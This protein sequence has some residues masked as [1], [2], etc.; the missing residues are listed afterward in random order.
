MLQCSKSHWA[1]KLQRSFEWKATACIDIV[2]NKFAKKSLFSLHLKIYRTRGY[3]K[4]H[5]INAIYSLSLDNSIVTWYFGNASFNIS[6]VTLNDFLCLPTHGKNMCYLKGKAL[7]QLQDILKSI[8]YLIIGEFPAIGLRILWWIN[9]CLW[10]V[11]EL[12]NA[13]F[14]GRFI[15]VGGIAKLPPVLNRPLNCLSTDD[16]YTWVIIHIKQWIM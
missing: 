4:S 14:G 8:K 13:I 15:Q 7:V 10:Q 5:I 2:K 11:S 12:M 16:Y 3:G 6:G 1:F 9:S